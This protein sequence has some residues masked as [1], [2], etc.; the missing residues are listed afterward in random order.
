MFFNVIKKCGDFMLLVGNGRLVTRD[1]DNPF[2]ENGAVLIDGGRIQAVGETAS[3]RALNINVPFEDA[4]NALIMPGLINAHDHAYSAL[5]R[6]MGVRG[7]HPESFTEILEGLW[8]KLDR[9]LNMD[10]I[11]SSAAV[12]FIDCI[13]NGVTT[14]F[15]H[16]ASYG[17][18]DGSLSVLSDMARQVGLRACLCYEVSDREGKEKMRSAVGENAA[19][20]RKAAGDTDGMQAGMM[21]LHASLTLSDETLEQC[22]EMMPGDVS[23]H[24]HV[25]EA[26]DDVNYTMQHY[27][28]RVVTRLFER[29]VLGPKTIAAHCVHVDAEEMTLLRESGTVVIHN[30]QSNMSNAVGC[31]K[32]IEMLHEGILVGL[33]TD[34]YT[35]DML[36]SL[37]AGCLIHKH[38]L[39]DTNAAVTEMT[40]MLFQNNAVLTERI[41]GVQTGVLKAGYAADLIALDYDPPTP[42]SAD[43]IDGHCLFGLYGAQVTMTMVNGR[44]LMRDRALVGVDEA[45]VRAKSR[46]QAAALWKRINS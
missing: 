3:L 29:G 37:K 12:A 8:W 14:L 5:A 19:F 43:N 26:A 45:A 16:H 38:R 28:K 42:M 11:V 36:E 7:F 34:G 21:G 30:P 4:K 44:V 25:A 1:G 18:I 27:G 13:K 9:T 40:T 24:V 17:S 10:D 33:G 41:F 35:K 31:G 20:M 46:G 23:C 39:Q 22:L 32:A 15:D 6:G 2:L